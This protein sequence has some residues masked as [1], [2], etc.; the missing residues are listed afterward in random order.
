MFHEKRIGLLACITIFLAGCG[1]GGGIDAG[2]ASSGDSGVRLASE[3]A[4]AKP[5]GS[6]DANP[7]GSAGLVPSKPSGSSTTTPPREAAPKASTG[8]VVAYDPRA[9]PAISGGAP[10]TAAWP[11]W[12]KPLARWQW[13]QIPGTDLSSIVPDPRVPGNLA[14]RIDAWN[15]LA[16]DTRTNRIYSAGNGGHADY[17]GNEVYEIDLSVDAPR[18]RMLRAPTAAA[19][20]VRSD[21]SKSVYNDYYLDGRPTST[22]TYYALQFL[23]SRNAIFKFG[24]GSLWGTGNEANWRTDAFSLDNFD[25]QPA[26]TW[27]DVLPNSRR[28]VTG[29]STCINPATDEVYVAAPGNLR[30]FDPASG[31]F[32]AL[33]AWIENSSEVYAR[34]CA[35]D[36]ARNRVVFFGDRYR[37]PGG[38][39]VYDLR[40]N[41]LTRFSFTGEGVADITGKDYNFVWFDSRI[42]RFLLKTGI[43]D[44]VYAIDPETFAVAKVGTMGGATLP[45]AANG[46]QTRWQHLPKLGGYAYYPRYG[47]GVWFLATE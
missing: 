20:I 22:H 44:V 10:S 3:S 8:S 32:T 41:T 11:A 18:W 9:L 37:I 15:G 23:A 12:R 6:P 19:D 47:S 25:W 28:A 29:A 14:A 13:F 5:W 4:T 38:G 21:F 1:G 27:P 46:V 33:A 45:D 31:T 36:A 2:A 40:S 42:N 43:S 26:A 7:A 17:S 30:R 16:A 35:V 39:L 34:G 24:A